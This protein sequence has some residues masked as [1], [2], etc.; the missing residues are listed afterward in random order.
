MGDRNWRLPKNQVK[1]KAWTAARIRKEFK[2]LTDVEKDLYRYW[3]DLTKPYEQT[4]LQAARYSFGRVL[5][6]RRSCPT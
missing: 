4:K 5:V 1:L 3:V 6:S 2:L